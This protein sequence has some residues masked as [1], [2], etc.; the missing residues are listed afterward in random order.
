MGPLTFLQLEWKPVNLQ[1]YDWGKHLHVLR[2]DL[3]K[4]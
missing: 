2:P 3:L 1:S 4:S